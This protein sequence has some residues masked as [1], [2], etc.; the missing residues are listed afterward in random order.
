MTKTSSLGIAG[1]TITLQT[2]KL[3]TQASGS[4][5][6][7]CG[8]TMILATCVVSAKP[9]ENVDFF[10]LSVDYEEKMYAVGK[11]PGGFF[12][13]EGKPSEKAILTSRLIDRPIRPL[14]P[15]GF[16]NEV[17]IVVTPLSVDEE[18][19][20]DVLSIIGASAAL[21]ISEIPF[22][23]PV[24]AVRIARLDGNF[25]ANPSSAELEK[26]DLDLVIVGTKER[27][28]M[29]EAAAKEVSEEDFI[30]AINFSKDY[31]SKTI[32]LQIDLQKQV[33]VEKMQF[34]PYKPNPLVEDFIRSNF[35]NDIKDALN[36]ADK[37]KQ[38]EKFEFIKSLI[39]EK[40]K[41]SGNE[42]MISSLEKNP[43]DISF[44]VKSIQKKFV[45]S[46]I[47][48]T[49]IRP[50]GRKLD[51]I[52]S[53]SCEVGI[54]PKAHGSALF[55]RGLTQALTVVTL[56]SKG[57]AQIIDGLSTE[58][59]Q[60]R[61]IHHYNM[62]A[63][64]VGEVKPLR[65]PGRREIGHGAL[66]EKALLPVIPSEEEFPYTIRLVSEILGSNGSSSMASTCGS[67][68]ALMDAGVPIKAAVA[69]IAMGLVEEDGKYRVF[70]DLQG[71]EDFLGDMDF[72]IAGTSKGITAIQLDIKNS[73]LTDEI[74]KDTLFLAKEGRNYILQKMLE[75]ISSPRKELSENAPRVISFSINPDKIGL[76]IGPSGKNIKKIIEETGAQIDIEND[77]KIFITSTN[78]EN[79]LSAKKRILSIAE[80]IEVGKVYTGE[81]TRIM[82]F[83]AIVEVLPGKD[84]MVH[85]SKLARK[86]VNKVEDVVKIGD[87]VLVKVLEIDPQGRVVLTMVF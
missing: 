65:G 37:D 40:I 38:I 76:V 42:E 70:S 13:R 20:P 5:V 26:S 1:K 22:L 6:V 49:N 57:D 7:N 35:E 58:E 68:L 17:Q 74:I 33:G 14:F 52:R 2:G 32:D 43:F 11:I 15:E 85:I 24:G 61:Y 44:V 87:K 27:I 12:K 73:G 41:S 55:T 67:T 3:A 23:G 63:Y 16:R 46:M 72:K 53:I 86:R 36:I 8:D 39:E 34:E 31:I 78:A 64:S 80:D 19:L 82:P 47:I 71:L 66:A 51:Q 28:L 25:I 84:G 48:D 59:S 45:R 60:K 9:K 62:P 30:S 54:V 56:G 83:G 18:N 75:T 77:G 79:A 81:V 29:I 50:D 21:T 4:V 69:G 10:P